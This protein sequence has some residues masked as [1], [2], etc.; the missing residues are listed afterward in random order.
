[1]ECNLPHFDHIFHSLHGTESLDSKKTL[2]DGSNA[3]W[4]HKH[5]MVI[6]LTF[7]KAGPLSLDKIDLQ[8]TNEQNATLC[9]SKNFG[10]K[11]IKVQVIS[12]LWYIEMLN[13]IWCLYS[14]RT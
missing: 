12:T 10:G 3:P 6:W 14:Y 8:Q 7:N 11:C 9:P 1:M 5:T 4:P 13:L 2:T